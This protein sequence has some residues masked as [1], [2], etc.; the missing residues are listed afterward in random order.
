MPSSRLTVRSARFGGAALLPLALAACG[1]SMNDNHFAPPCPRTAIL[2]DAGD[3]AQ[4]RPG[5]RDLT[6]LLLQARIAS[7]TGVCEPGTAKDTTKVTLHVGLTAQRGP[8]AGE[9]R[10]ADLSYFVAVVRNNQILTKRV[11]ASPFQFP[12]NANR[13]GITGADQE[14]ILPTPDGT[15][16]ADYVVLVGLQ[17][18]QDQLDSNRQALQ[19]DQ[20][21]A[22]GI[23]AG[24]GQ[25][26]Q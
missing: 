22:S 10:D 18:S 9:Q 1:P 19:Q 12:A 17:L 13:V 2:S 7:V 4:Y 14:I 15:T 23:G 24:L 8:A 11:I 6:D 16:A 20:S 26:G 5:G 21:G 3:L 25:T